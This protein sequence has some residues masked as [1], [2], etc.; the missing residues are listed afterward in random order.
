MDNLCPTGGLTTRAARNT[1][2][3]IAALGAAFAADDGLDALLF[4]K[5]GVQ[6]LNDGAVADGLAR[7][8]R[9]C[10]VLGDVRRVL[11]GRTGGTTGAYPRGSALV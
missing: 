4:R 2:T 8:L 5:K 7:G 10:E 3:R 6:G 11:E 1:A 9:N